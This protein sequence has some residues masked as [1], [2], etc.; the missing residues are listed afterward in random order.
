MKS[1]KKDW[2][3]SGLIDFEYKKYTLLAYLKEVKKEFDQ[4]RLYPYLS[5]LVIHYQNLVSFKE[6][7]TFVYDSFPQKLTQA[8]LR[9]LELVYEKI[10][11]DD[12]MM[13]EL[14]EIVHF[15]IPQL[16]EVVND[17]KDIYESVQE[18][19]QIAPVGI[20]VLYTD[21]GYFFLQQLNVD[22]TSIYQYQITFFES[23]SGR[24]R[25]IHTSY[26][27]SVK[28]TLTS[29]PEA[30]KISLV[31]RYK[32]L[33]VPASYIIEVNIDYPFHETILPI[34]KRNFVK[35]LALH[36]SPTD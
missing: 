35:Y 21:E 32:H 34:V 20:N 9:N 19:I 28:R 26:I 16:E 13:K 5:D 12:A 10:V 18:H 11:Q 24:Y 31:K 1:L 6:N 2:L 25:G 14:E 8:D 22:M 30:L 17:G 15:A 23:S 4:H 36:Q 27:E 33:P 7:K 3:T 29:T